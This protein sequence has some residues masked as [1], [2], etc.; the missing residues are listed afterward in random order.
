MSTPR[1]TPRQQ[2]SEFTFDA[3]LDAA[4]R[5]FHQHGYAATTTNKVAELAGVSIGTLY[6]YVPNKDAL[7]FALAERHLRQAAHALLTEAAALRADQ[8]PLGETVHRLITAVAHL[9]SAQPRMHRLLFEQ[10]P[11]TPE[12]VA[13]LRQLEQRLADEVTYHLCRLD[14]GGSDPALTALLFVQAVEAQVH[15]AVLN[16]PSGRTTEQCVQAVIDF[17]T[18]SLT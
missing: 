15:G 16:P 2:R 4:A 12:G 7:L 18:R 8:P 13:Q 10:A 14:V 11:R 1:K 17:W 3:I 9:H 6:H 5:L